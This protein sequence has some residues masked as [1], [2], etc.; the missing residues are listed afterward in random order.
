MRIRKSILGALIAAVALAVV[1]LL[2][3]DTLP[4]RSMTHGAIH[5]CKR[6]VLRYAREHGRLPSTLSE[7]QPIKGYYSSIKDA[8][9]VVLEYSV[10]SNNVVT[11]RSLGKDKIPGGTGENADM[12]GIFHAR[13]PDGTW[14]DEFVDWTRDPF[15]DLAEREPN[16]EP[17]ATR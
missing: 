7:T 16:K 14:A 2:F 5:M 12:T 15:N 3:V 8:W 9:G 6:R 10:D 4:P 13:A 17:K 1:A 11:F